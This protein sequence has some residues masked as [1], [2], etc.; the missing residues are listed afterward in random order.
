MTGTHPT[1]YEARRDA[2]QESYHY[3]SEQRPGGV[4]EAA[5]DHDHEALDLVHSAREDREGEQG[6]KQ[7]AGRHGHHGTDAEAQGKDP[8]ELIPISSA[9]SRLFATALIDLPSRVL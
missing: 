6:R 3:S 9:A 7:R 4:A 1:G 5:E 8:R 2:L